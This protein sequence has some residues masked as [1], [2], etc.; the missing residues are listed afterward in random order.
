M[1]VS[2]SIPEIEKVVSSAT[3]VSPKGCWVSFSIPRLN[4]NNNRK[5]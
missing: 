3:S 2:F 4:I 1:W 5:L